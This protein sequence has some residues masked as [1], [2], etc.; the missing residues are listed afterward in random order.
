MR[1]DK[2]IAFK[3]R[4]RQNSKR[5]RGHRQHLTVVRIAEILTDGAQPAKAR[6]AKAEPAAPPSG[7]P[8]LRRRPGA[9]PRRRPGRTPRQPSPGRPGSAAAAVDAGGEDTNLSLISGIGSTTEKKL[10]AAGV[11]TWNDIAGWSEA[12]VARYDEELGLRG[13]TTREEWVAQAKEL[14]DGKPPRAKVDQAEKACGKDRSYGS[15]RLLTLFAVHGVDNAEAIRH[16]PP[17]QL[18]VFAPSRRRRIWVFEVLPWLTR[19]QVVRRA[20]VVIRPDVA[21]A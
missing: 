4:R 9:Q 16:C 5:R 3:K 20:T 18:N 21:L 17:H 12:D 7:P 6:P 11:G 10:R 13:R 1:D 2:V 14:L 15:R 8:R 19:R